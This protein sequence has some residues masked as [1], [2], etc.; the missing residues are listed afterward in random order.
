MLAVGN[1]V[2]ADYSAT[3]I[4]GKIGIGLTSPAARLHLA[5]GTATAGTA[6]LK[7]TIKTKHNKSGD[8]IVGSFTI[9]GYLGEP[10][11]AGSFFSFNGT[12]SG[13]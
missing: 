13:H 10:I 9:V 1:G 3:L 4:A 5:S 7:I 12:L 11:K 8:Y 2:Q 6:P